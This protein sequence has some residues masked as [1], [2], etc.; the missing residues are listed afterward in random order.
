MTMAEMEAELHL[1]ITAGSETV[2]T[3]L[4]GTINYPC[5]NPALLKT[6]ANEVR[7]AVSVEADL[8]VANLSQLHYLTGVLKE[9]LRIVCP[10]PI[11][12][13]RIAP[14]TGAS[15]CGYWVPGHVSLIHLFVSPFRCTPA[16]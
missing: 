11:S 13:P 15:I 14:S 1:L 3:V 6:L 4:S 16:G 10:T 7:S 2:A 8:T 9:G 5:Q 12:F